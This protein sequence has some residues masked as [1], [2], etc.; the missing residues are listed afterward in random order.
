MLSP[1]T[2]KERGLGPLKNPKEDVL[3]A[4]TLLSLGCWQYNSTIMKETL[5][6]SSPKKSKKKK[7]SIPQKLRSQ[8]KPW[9]ETRKREILGALRKAKDDMVL[10]AALLGIGKTTIYRALELYR[11][12]G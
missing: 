7:I 10:A 12:T 1:T 9:Q 4:A 8:I 11:K 5:Q 2:P 6:M 3:L